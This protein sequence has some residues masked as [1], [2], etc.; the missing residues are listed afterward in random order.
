MGSSRSG[1]LYRWRGTT[2]IASLTLRAPSRSDGKFTI[3]PATRTA[4]Q[5]R[6]AGNFHLYGD[7]F[8]EVP[9]DRDALAIN[10]YVC[11]KSGTGATVTVA[12]AGSEQRVKVGR[13]RTGSPTAERHCDQTHRRGRRGRGPYTR[14]D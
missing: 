9:N 7:G 8:I 2:R 3:L 5:F 4:Y 1:Q 11:E 10:H 13:V 12:A 6:A 14:R